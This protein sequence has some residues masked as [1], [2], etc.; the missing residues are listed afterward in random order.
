MHYSS[1]II[2]II[3]NISCLCFIYADYVLAKFAF[4]ICLHCFMLLVGRH[5]GHP[6][7]KN[8]SG[9]VLAWLSA[10]CRFAYGPCDATATHCQLLQ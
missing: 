5:E 10:W 6:A 9:E 3:K 1:N 4:H 8:L 2:I 7:C